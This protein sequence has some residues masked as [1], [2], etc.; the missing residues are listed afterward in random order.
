MPMWFWLPALVLAI[1]TA[2][3]LLIVWRGTRRLSGT[4]TLF[5]QQ[6]NRLQILFFETASALGK[7]RGLRWT[8][9]D[10]GDRVEFARDRK[11][12]QL[13]AFV[14]V[15]IAFEAIEGGDMEGVAAVGNL[16][17]ASAVF[18]FDGAAWTTVGRAIFNLNPDEAIQHLREHY[19]RIVA[20]ARTLGH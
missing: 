14:G 4:M 13:F 18:A 16:R 10:W 2:A 7:P 1:L 8:A 12:G 5:D 20:P 11:T 19:E 6:R 15:T 9:C 3:M 17:N